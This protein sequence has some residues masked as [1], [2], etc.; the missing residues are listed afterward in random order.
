MIIFTNGCFDQIHIGHIRLL[1]YCHD[2]CLKESPSIMDRILSSLVVR[3]RWNVIVGLNNDNSVRRL[4]GD[5]R[6][7]YKVEH[8]KEVLKSIKYVDQVFIFEEDTPLELIK[9]LRPDIIVKGGDYKPE[10]VVGNEYAEVRIFP[11]MGL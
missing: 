9:N 3:H 7:K 6:P 4:K 8:R 1:K 10:E 11:L 5:D 2:I